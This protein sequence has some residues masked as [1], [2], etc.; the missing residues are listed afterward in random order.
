MTQQ[1]NHKKNVIFEQK[2]IHAILR[3]RTGFFHRFC[4]T[5]INK[6]VYKNIS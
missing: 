4:F 1:I 6:L 3:K 2:N 5:G